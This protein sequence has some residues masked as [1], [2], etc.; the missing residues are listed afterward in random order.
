MDQ[1]R[2]MLAVLSSGTRKRLVL[3][4]IGSALV[5]L[6]EVVGLLMI[7]PLMQLLTGSTA[8]EG[9]VKVMANIFNTTDTNT[10]AIISA[11]LVFAAFLAKGLLTVLFRWWMLGFLYREE[12]ETSLMLLRYYV[13]APYQLHLQRNSADLIRTMNDAVGTVFSF[14][15]VGGIGAL[16]EAATIT[17]VLGTLL[18][19]M[20]LPTVGVALYF[21]LTGF[22]FARAM[23]RRAVRYGQAMIDGSLAIYQGAMQTLGGV[24]EIKIRHKADHFLAIY[25]NARWD[26]ASARRAAAF[27]NDLPKYFME[28]LFIV[29]IALTAVVIFTNNASDEALTM[30]TLFVAAG[31]RVLPSTVRLLGATNGIRVGVGSL[32]LIVADMQAASALAHETDEEERDAEPLVVRR[33]VAVRDLRFRYQGSDED[34]I[35]GIDLDLPAGTSTALVGVSGAG[36]STLVDLVLGLHTPRSGSISVDG[37]DIRTR[38]VS[39]QR[40]I[41]L[42]PQDV[43]LLDDTLRANIAFGEAPDQVDEERLRQAVTRA[44]LDPL[45]A[46]LSHGLDTYAG[47][48][49]VRISGGQRQRI[50][51]A[52]ALY[53][54]PS[55]LI[56][57]EATSALD[58]ETERRVTE[59]IDSL[60]GS[61]TIIVVAHRLSTVRDC[62]QV[63]FLDQ[64]TV[65]AAGSFEDVRRASDTFAHLVRLGRLEPDDPAPAGSR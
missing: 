44:Q 12:A 7:L 43:Y 56:L 54:R 24:K 14:V 11:A 8:D 5:G 34:V 53:G 59:I 3:A 55:V 2:A 61:L 25:R 38:M 40:S 32:D 27:I 42:V 21:G 1:L 48:R 13:R 36:K 18:V 58:N 20:P 22:F 29:G 52:R 62:D 31:F 51:I 47:E 63:V 30:L 39:W 17:F 60:R 16:G 49:G 9:A 64:G 10:L 26:Y 46:Q 23:R 41:G 65:E 57:D 28:I 33:E 19:L 35:R 4:V 45:V 6:A 50:G 15:I 37:H